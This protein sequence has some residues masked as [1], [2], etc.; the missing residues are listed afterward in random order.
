MDDIISVIFVIPKK[1]KQNKEQAGAG[2]VPSSGL[3]RSLSQV[4]V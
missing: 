4:E 1:I 3:A 2:V